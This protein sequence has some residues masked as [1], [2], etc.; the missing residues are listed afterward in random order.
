LLQCVV[1]F[2]YF[3]FSSRRRHT[4]S[5]R[6]WSSDVC[7]SDLGFCWNDINDQLGARVCPDGL[8]ISATA[9]ERGCESVFLESPRGYAIRNFVKRFR[10]AYGAMES[11]RALHEMI[12]PDDH[13]LFR[14]EV[15]EGLG[16]GRVRAGWTR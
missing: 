5:K 13:T 4:R 14:S 15:L 7:S 3:F 9:G 1:L 11:V 8:L 12:S 2:V 10:L 6:D 16:T